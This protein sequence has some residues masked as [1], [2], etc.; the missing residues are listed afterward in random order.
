M[1]GEDKF[2]NGLALGK[3]LFNGDV[4]IG[5]EFKSTKT[6]PRYMK[7]NF[8]CHPIYK[9]KVLADTDVCDTVILQSFDCGH[10]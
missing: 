5:G 3:G 10:Q 2:I 8:D 7:I 1:S 4:E 9:G 6:K